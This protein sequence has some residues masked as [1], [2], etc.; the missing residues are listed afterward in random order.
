M[1]QSFNNQATSCKYH[2][3]INQQSSNNQAKRKQKSCNNQAEIKQKSYKKH[4][5]I[6]ILL[7]DCPDDVSSSNRYSYCG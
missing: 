5:T 6:S 3:T 1:Q 2:V 7:I 4:A